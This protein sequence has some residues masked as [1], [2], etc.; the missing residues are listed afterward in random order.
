[1]KG[2]EKKNKSHISEE[3][4]LLSIH[5]EDYN[6]NE[7]KLLDIQ[8][9]SKRIGTLEYIHLEQKKVHTPHCIKNKRKVK[10]FVHLTPP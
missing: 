9:Q 7:M 2:G 8:L 10:P 5:I 3:H 1:M 6:L 4:S